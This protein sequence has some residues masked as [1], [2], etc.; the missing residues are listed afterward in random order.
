M[1]LSFEM[2]REGKFYIAR[3]PELMVTT[4]GRNIAEAKENFREALTLHIKCLI[5]YLMKHRNVRIEFGKIIPIR[6]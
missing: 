1:K 6:S 3:C 4:Q 2:L 5:D